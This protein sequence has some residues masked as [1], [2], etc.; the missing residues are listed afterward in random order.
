MERQPAATDKTYGW[1]G[2]GEEWRGSQQQLTIFMVGVAGVK[3]GEAT[4]SN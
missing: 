1:S 3:N 4:S 2:R